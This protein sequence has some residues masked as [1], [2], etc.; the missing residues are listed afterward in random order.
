ML[1]TSGGRESPA[2]T[3]STLVLN[4]VHLISPVSGHAILALIEN[5]FLHGEV[6]WWFSTQPHLVLGLGHSREHV[7]L[8]FERVL[9]F[10]PVVDLNILLLVEFKSE[11]VLFS[12]SVGKTIRFHM[13]SELLLELSGSLWLEEV[14]ET[15]NGRGFSKLHHL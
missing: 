12:G 10:V 3:T 14:L 15:E 6:F 5:G 13:R 1:S 9:V 7:V 8:E 2:G 11:I 4:G